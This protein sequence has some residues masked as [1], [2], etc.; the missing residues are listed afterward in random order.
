MLSLENVTISRFAGRHRGLPLRKACLSLNLHLEMTDTAG[1]RSGPPLH[2]N[3][4][5]STSQARPS[6]YARVWTE[7]CPFERVIIQSNPTKEKTSRCFQREAFVKRDNPSY[8]VIN[9]IP[10]LARN[11][12]MLFMVFHQMKKRKTSLCFQRE[13]FITRDNP[14][15]GVI[16][17]I[18]TLAR[19]L[20]M[21][22]WFS[23]K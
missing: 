11:L 19:S 4:E 5:L 14:S 17:T 23:I 6:P 7:A 3:V 18:P 8:G 9:T 12:S 20:S 1:G 16:N 13:A 22:R 10:T 21:L 2:R 15:Y